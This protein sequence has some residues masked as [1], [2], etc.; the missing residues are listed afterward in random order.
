MCVNFPGHLGY[1][2]LTLSLGAQFRLLALD[3][4]QGTPTCLAGLRCWIEYLLP[5]W[6]QFQIKKPAALMGQPSSVCREQHLCAAG[7]ASYQHLLRF[8]NTLSVRGTLSIH[9]LVSAMISLQKIWK[10]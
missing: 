2:V 7:A 10:R 8:I 4:P 9:S 5:T 1:N 3:K 6:D